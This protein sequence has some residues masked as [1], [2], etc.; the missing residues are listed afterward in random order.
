MNL[1]DWPWVGPNSPPPSG[2][3]DPATVLTNIGKIRNILLPSAEE[4]CEFEY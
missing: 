2:P 3:V 4:L 1:K